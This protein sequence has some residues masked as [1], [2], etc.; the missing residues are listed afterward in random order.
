MVYLEMIKKIAVESKKFQIIQKK[1]NEAV[2][3]FKNS[4]CKS[5]GFVPCYFDFQ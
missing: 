1:V 2:K 3:N 4:F 5:L